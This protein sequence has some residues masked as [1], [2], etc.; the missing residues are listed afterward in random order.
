MASQYKDKDKDGGVVLSFNGRWV[1]WAHTT[2]AYGASG[3]LPLLFVTEPPA[4][5]SLS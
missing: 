5:P 4:N 2:F 1:S 3:P